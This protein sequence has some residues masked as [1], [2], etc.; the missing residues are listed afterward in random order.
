ML[1]VE[2]LT[3]IAPILG[4]TADQAGIVLGLVFTVVLALCGGMISQR[5]VSISMGLPALLGL[6]L[7]TY[8]QWL[9]Y[10]TGGAIALVVA[11]LIAWRLSG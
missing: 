9:P 7:F 10:F 3:S 6:L 8:A 4:L 1:W 5:N 11:L 2:W